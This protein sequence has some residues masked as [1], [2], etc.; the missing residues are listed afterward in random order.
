LDN[1]VFN[2]PYQFSTSDIRISR[3]STCRIVEQDLA[4]Y[5]TYKGLLI[6]HLSKESTYSTFSD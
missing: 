1:K 5:V 3:R 4:C 2:R 6:P